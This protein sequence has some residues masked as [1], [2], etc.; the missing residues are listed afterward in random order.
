[1][2]SS[3]LFVLK[4]VSFVGKENVELIRRIRDMLK[5]IRNRDAIRPIAFLKVKGHSDN[6]WNDRADELAKL[7][8]NLL[9]R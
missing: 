2:V 5:E 9:S 3:T 6:R 8:A 1:M 4:C 7:G